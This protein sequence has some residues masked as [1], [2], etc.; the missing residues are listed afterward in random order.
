MTFMRKPKCWN[1]ILKFQPS[2]KLCKF[3]NYANY[4][5]SPAHIIVSKWFF[6]NVILC[7]AISK[8]IKLIYAHV[9]FYHIE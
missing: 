2:Q 4:H 3:Q 8:V 1:P 7:S 5:I 6:Q 9:V